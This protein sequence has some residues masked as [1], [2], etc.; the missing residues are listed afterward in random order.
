MHTTT[1]EGV[2]PAMLTPFTK[3]DKP[4]FALF[5]KNINAQVAAG[6]EGVIIGGS[7]GEA[8]TLADHGPLREYN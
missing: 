7:L 4:D 2:F 1:W 3:D 6:S 5:E 8:S